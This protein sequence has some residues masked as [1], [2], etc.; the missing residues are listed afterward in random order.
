MNH[1]PLCQVPLSATHLAA[2][3]PAFTCTICNGIWLTA[4]EYVDWSSSHYPRSI[5]EV[6]IA[7]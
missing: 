5:Q 2:T 7:R 1:C 4:N 3:L 6:Y